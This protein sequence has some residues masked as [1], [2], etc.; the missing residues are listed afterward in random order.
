MCLFVCVHI[1]SGAWHLPTALCN[2]FCQRCRHHYASWPHGISL[3]WQLKNIQCHSIES[4]CF[5]ACRQQA[6]LP[7]H[8]PCDFTS[9]LCTDFV[10]N[11]WKLFFLFCREWTVFHIWKK[12]LHIYCFCYLALLKMLVG[13]LCWMKL[14]SLHQSLIIKPLRWKLLNL[15]TFYDF[16]AENSQYNLFKKIMKYQYWHIGILTQ[17]CYNHVLYKL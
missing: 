2:W 17:W 7:V 4:W 5:G 9:Q 14:A 12:L 8:W 13:F 16:S 3:C 1:V 6:S 11:L 10:E 15:L